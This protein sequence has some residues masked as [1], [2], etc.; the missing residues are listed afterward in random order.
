M[1]RIKESQ[2]VRRLWQYEYYYD[3]RTE[4]ESLKGH[5]YN[6]SESSENHPIMPK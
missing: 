3:E 2:Q 4:T 5:Y 6:F 1:P